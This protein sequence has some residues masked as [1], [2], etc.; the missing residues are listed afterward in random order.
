M[1]RRHAVVISL[2]LSLSVVAG[3]SAVVRTAH[4][5][6]PGPT[7]DRA[8]DAAVAQRR[9]RLD[10][11]AASLSKAEEARPPKLPQVPRFAPVSIPQMPAAAPPSSSLA[12]QPSA[13]PPAPAQA[14]AATAPKVVTEY[15]HAPAAATASRGEHDDED[16]HADEHEE[17]HHDE[18]QSQELGDD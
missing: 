9:N 11:W 18:D 3:A 10:R 5:G 12:S 6:R 16:E 15:V 4:V 14:A 13:P 7:V 17:E 2:L 1:N 8:S